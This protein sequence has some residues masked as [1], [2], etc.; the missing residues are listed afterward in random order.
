M[1]AEKEE[2]AVFPKQVGLEGKKK[3]KRLRFL[4]GRLEK[5]S[6]QRPKTGKSREVKAKEI[7]VVEF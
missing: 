5:W 3:K 4:D 7:A 6:Y 2:S 1:E